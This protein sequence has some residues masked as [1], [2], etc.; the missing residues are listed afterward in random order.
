[1][2]DT[3]GPADSGGFPD[4]SGGGVAG[5]IG[6]IYGRTRTTSRG[7]AAVASGLSLVAFDTCPDNYPSSCASVGLP[8]VAEAAA[9]AKVFG[10]GVQAFANINP[11]APYAGLAFFL[12]I[13]WMP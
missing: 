12:Q 11:K 4:T 10:L 2:V 1:M 3:G 6:L 8:I 7:H 5:E 9:N 13:G